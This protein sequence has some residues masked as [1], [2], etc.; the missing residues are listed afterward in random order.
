MALVLSRRK[1]DS[2][3]I[4]DDVEVIYQGT[5]DGK[6]VLEIRAPAEIDVHR[7]EIYDKIKEQNEEAKKSMEDLENVPQQ[8]SAGGNDNVQRHHGGYVL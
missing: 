4:G 8:G 5:R 6:G 7:R 2:I 1:G 3:M